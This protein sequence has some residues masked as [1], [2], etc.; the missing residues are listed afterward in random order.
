MWLAQ[1]KE[2]QPAAGPDTSFD[3]VQPHSFPSFSSLALHFRW[4]LAGGLPFHPLGVYCLNTQ[5][6]KQDHLVK[7]LLHRSLRLGALIMSCHCRE[8]LV[9]V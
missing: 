7:S 2:P 3:S 4:S 9:N 5:V 6:A 8:T 1:G